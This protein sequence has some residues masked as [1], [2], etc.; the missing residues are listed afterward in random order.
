M[1]GREGELRMD[2]TL[3]RDYRDFLEIQGL[4]GQVDVSKVS[5]ELGLDEEELFDFVNQRVIKLK[6]Q[7]LTTQSVG[8]SLGTLFLFAY[9][10]RGVRSVS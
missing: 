10:L 7:G 9:W 5:G 8:E 6:E 2:Q 4:K 1:T 3:E